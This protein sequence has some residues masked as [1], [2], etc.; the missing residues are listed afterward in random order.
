[1]EID[2]GY[3]LDADEDDENEDS[4]GEEG[5]EYP[6]E[7]CPQC[8][9]TH[10]AIF[11]GERYSTFEVQAPI[12]GLRRG[13]FSQASSRLGIRTCM[14]CGYVELYHEDVLRLDD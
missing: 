14:D 12:P 8:G 7:P 3:L 6:P 1:M 2:D 13:L 11:F 10:T 9:R 5:T 4:E